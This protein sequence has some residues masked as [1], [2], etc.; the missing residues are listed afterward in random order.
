MKTITFTKGELKALESLLLDSNPCISGCTY[1]EMQNKKQ[2]CD[3]CPYT[4]N[5]YSVM[6]KLK[7]L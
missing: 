1:P 4:K 7:I 6:E 3:K 5:I 2:D